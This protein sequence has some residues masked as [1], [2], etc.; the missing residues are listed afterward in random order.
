MEHIFIINPASGIK[1]RSQEYIQRIKEIMKSI[2]E[3]YKIALTK[4]P[5]HATELAEVFAGTGRQT[6]IYSIGGDGTLN[7]V[8][9][10]CYKYP[11]VQLAA[12]PAGTGNDFIKTFPEYDFTDMEGLIRGTGKKIDL[13]KYNGRACIN[14]VNCGFDAEVARNVNKFKKIVSGNLAYYLSLFFS[15]IKKISFDLKIEVDGKEVSNQKTAITAVAN[16]RVYGGGFI[17]GPLAEVDDG[18]LDIVIAKGMSRLKITTFVDKY[19]TGNHDALGDL[20]MSIR[21]KSVRITSDKLFS[22]CADGEVSQGTECSIEILPGAL[23]F[24]L[25]ASSKAEK[26]APARQAVLVD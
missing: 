17:A 9:N 8:L 22:I 10:G 13:M 19:K 1:D 23:T 25:P 26:N 7:E 20:M 5:K 6:R 21:G 14:I 15:F 24:V 12:Y 18:I 3:P 2:S 11:N 16:G 4:Y